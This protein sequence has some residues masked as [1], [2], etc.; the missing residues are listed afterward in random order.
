MRLTSHQEACHS[1]SCDVQVADLRCGVQC[2]PD[3]NDVRLGGL[4]NLRRCRLTM[5]P[6]RNS[7]NGVPVTLDEGS[8]SSLRHLQVGHVLGMRPLPMLVLPPPFARG[9]DHAAASTSGTLCRRRSMTYYRTDVPT[10][11]MQRV[12]DVDRFT[13]RI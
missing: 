12:H 5:V 9:A 11:G 7:R 6:R 10:P 8:L 3:G 4:P 2:G 13:R 1:T